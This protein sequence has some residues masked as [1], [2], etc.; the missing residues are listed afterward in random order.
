MMND[1]LIFIN[2]IFNAISNADK[3]PSTLKLLETLYPT[4]FLE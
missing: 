4:I 2:P 1:R 3:E